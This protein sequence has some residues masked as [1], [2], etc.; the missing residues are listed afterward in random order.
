MDRL[1]ILR[2]IVADMPECQ[3]CGGFVTAQYARVFTPTGVD[4]P[5][6]CPDCED[7]MR[8][9]GDIREARSPRQ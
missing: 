8:D 3:N 6:V 1:N 5:R 2:R 9:N 4:Q 7:L